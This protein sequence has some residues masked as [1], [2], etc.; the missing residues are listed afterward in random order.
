VDRCVDIASVRRWR[1]CAG[2]GM[3]NNPKSCRPGVQPR[4]VAQ[5]R[6]VTE[7]IFGGKRGSV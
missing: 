4:L 2:E 5:M 1:K 7:V 6:E 3:M